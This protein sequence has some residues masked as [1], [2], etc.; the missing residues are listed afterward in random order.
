MDVGTRARAPRALHP[1]LPIMSV[2]R[3]FLLYAIARQTRA[4]SVGMGDAFD[5][6]DIGEAV[7]HL[8]F[9]RVASI[10]AIEIGGANG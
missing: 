7:F 5:P 3:R 1:G 8:D 2:A 4:G 9:D 10:E 6:W